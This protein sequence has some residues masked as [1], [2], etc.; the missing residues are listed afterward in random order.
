MKNIVLYCKSY[1]NDYDRVK[2]LIESIQ[3]YNVDNILFYLSVPSKDI[4]AFQH[5]VNNFVL[6]SD[7]EIYDIPKEFTNAYKN[8]QI[9]K[10]NFWRL[11]LCNNY[12]CLDSDS[13]FIKN[14]YINDFIYSNDIPYT[15]VSEQKDLFQWSANNK[16]NLGFDPRVGFII[17]RT[18]V[19][20]VFGYENRRVIYDFGPSPVIWNCENWITLNRTFELQ[21]DIKFHELIYQI[22]SEF[23]WYGEWLLH[24]KTIP[25]YPREPLFKVFHYKKQYEDYIRQFGNI[26]QLKENYLGIILQSNWKI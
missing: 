8:Q 7:E 26:E 25:I 12:V 16:T 5:L 13:E 10:S 24:N 21:H 20:K 19:M 11:K 22:P 14:F 1:I 18:A 3:R 2:K 17:D 9:I 4:S 15:V 23:T 6:L